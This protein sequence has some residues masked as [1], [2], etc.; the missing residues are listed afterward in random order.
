MIRLDNMDR[1]AQ[2]DVRFLK[3]SFHRWLKMI[4]SVLLR[5]NSPKKPPKFQ[6]FFTRRRLGSSES[7]KNSVHTLLHA[8]STIKNSA[9]VIF[10]FYSL[11]NTQGARSGSAM[12]IPSITLIL[13]TLTQA[14]G[15][16]AMGMSPK[17]RSM[18]VETSG[19]RFCFPS[20]S[21]VRV[22]LRSSARPRNQKSPK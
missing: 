2:Y 10:E 18:R 14:V 12:P 9:I 17:E 8:M 15:Y 4:E 22:K 21:M 5:N 11:K 6:Y 20:F 7:Y 19:M 1:R 13:Q 16:S 3:F